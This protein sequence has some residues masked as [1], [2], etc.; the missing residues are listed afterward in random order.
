MICYSRLSCNPTVNKSP[1][2]KL[3]AGFHE[4]YAQVLFRDGIGGVWKSMRGSLE[5]RKEGREGGWTFSYE[6]TDKE[7][8]IG[9]EEVWGWLFMC[10]YHITTSYIYERKDFKCGN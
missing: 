9:V 8:R 3:I 6:Y 1:F 7:S 4:F 5:E 2:P 10:R